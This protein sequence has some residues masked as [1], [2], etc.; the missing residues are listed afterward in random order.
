MR[1]SRKEAD[2][3]EADII[4]VVLV[5]LGPLGWLVLVLLSNCVEN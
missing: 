2:S 3:I 1:I 5:L 4:S